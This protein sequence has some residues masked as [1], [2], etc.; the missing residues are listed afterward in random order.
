M[1]LA[2]AVVHFWSWRLTL[3]WLR[4]W[5]GLSHEDWRY[6]LERGTAMLHRYAAALLLLHCTAH[7]LR[8]LTAFA[9]DKPVTWT[10]RRSA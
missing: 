9:I 8:Q 10:L 5:D 4:S 1:L 2:T 3:N 6:V 7:C